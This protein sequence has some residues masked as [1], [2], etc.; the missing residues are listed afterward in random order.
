L[1]DTSIVNPTAGAHGD[2]SASELL[3]EW[4]SGRDAARPSLLKRS[5]ILS[6]AWCYYESR[7]LGAHHSLLSS[8]TLE[9][10]VLYVLL[11]HHEVATTPLSLLCTLIDT[12]CSFDW[13]SHVLS[14]HGPVPL[15]AMPRGTAA[16]PTSVLLRLVT[17]CMLRAARV[18][19]SGITCL[20]EVNRNS[21]SC[22]AIVGAVKLERE[23]GAAGLGG[24]DE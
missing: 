18:H 24:S 15:E 3:C 9:L 23:V 6:K 11:Y 22:A 4:G 21:W 7:I 16:G 17:V 20:L 5:I 1:L 12:V 10:L 14:I 19:C 2:K 8:Y 13:G